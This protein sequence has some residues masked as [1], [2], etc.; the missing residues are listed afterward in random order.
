MKIANISELKIQLLKNNV[1][2]S[3]YENVELK[4]NW[5]QKYGEKISM[6]CNGQTKIECYLVIGV[7]DDGQLA[8]HDE[9][10]LS[11]NQEII[12]QHT[13]TFLDPFITLEDITTEDVNGSKIII[14]RVRN[15]GAVVKWKGDAW[16]G[17]GTTKRKMLPEEILELSLNLPGLY[18]LTKKKLS[19]LPSDDCIKEFCSMGNIKY[20][21]N[22]LDR[23]RLSN[24]KC[25][26]LLFGSGSYRFVKYDEKNNVLLNENRLGL[27]SLL[28]DNTYKEIQRYYE[29]RSSLSNRISDEI[30]REA[31]GNCV[32]HAAYHENDGEIII[33]LYPNRISFSNLVYSEYI[34]LANKWFSSA[35][36]SPNPF[37][38]E[39]LR[40]GNRVDE[41]GR[42]KKKLI[43]ECLIN[44]FNPPVVTI[45]EAGRHK[46]WTLLITFAE[47]PERHAALRKALSELY[48]DQEKCI[49]AY[50]LIRWSHK[51]F[52][53]IATSFDNH[54]YKI[55]TKIIIDF[56]GPLFYW[57]ERDSIIP[58]RWVTVLLEEGKA[59]KGFSLHE[60]NE[61]FKRCAE[62]HNKYFSGYIT[63]MQLREIAH[64][65]NSN[66][67]KSLASRTLNKW[68]NDGKIKRIKRGTYIFIKK[69]TI[70]VETSLLQELFNVY[71]ERDNMSRGLQMSH[72]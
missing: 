20:D 9:S 33:E 35:R 68:V 44:G 17:K 40:I 32:G 16:N 53:E 67:D 7:E 1:T 60:E 2:E 66:S 55:A 69:D 43:S 34:S 18:D 13:N 26:D 12:S 36:K 56:K 22:V 51:P 19:F 57:K 64:L 23:Y 25:G 63:P 72:K 37:L 50:A 54:E 65:S 38:M 70:E 4:R 21:E 14:L 41:L 3:K 48:T 46:R 27:I 31:I 6:L 8:G 59:S 42:G 47:H 45:S 49:I 58:Q 62:L 30:L 24:T 71:K 61:L 29:E 28:S 39:I 5:G 15:P 10:W 11:S 52:S